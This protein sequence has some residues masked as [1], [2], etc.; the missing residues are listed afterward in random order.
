MAMGLLLGK[1]LAHGVDETMGFFDGNKK[2]HR[3]QTVRNR[4]RI[5]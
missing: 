2:A 3:L 5:N 4:I 1:V